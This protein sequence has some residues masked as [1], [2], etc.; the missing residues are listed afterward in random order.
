MNNQRRNLVRRDSEPTTLAR[1]MH[2]HKPQDETSVR[3][4]R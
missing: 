3:K 1:Q 4:A 2:Y